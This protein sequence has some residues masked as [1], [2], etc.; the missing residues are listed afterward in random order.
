MLVIQNAVL[1]FLAVSNIQG[2]KSRLLQCCRKHTPQVV[3][4]AE[5]TEPAQQPASTEQAPPED[6]IREDDLYPAPDDTEDRFAAWETEQNERLH[7]AEVFEQKGLILVRKAALLRAAIQCDNRG[8]TFVAN[9][10]RE[11]AQ[12]LDADP[13]T[14]TVTGDGAPILRLVGTDGPVKRG[15]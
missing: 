12:N 3:R 4:A 7:E 15:A 5:V 10:L 2:I 9:E 6:E 1:R 11:L 14:D 13:S 8:D